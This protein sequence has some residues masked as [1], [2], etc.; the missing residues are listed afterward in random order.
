MGR[1]EEFKMK[2]TKIV[3]EYV[4]EEVKKIFNNKT[5]IERQWDKQ[6]EEMNED[7]KIMEMRIKTL[8]EDMKTNFAK[9]YNVDETV[10]SYY[11]PSI[12]IN[13]WRGIIYL[14][15]KAKEEEQKRT[16][17]AEKAI[18][19]IL[20]SLELGGNKKVLEEMLLKLKSEV[21]K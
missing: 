18:K 15:Q 2:V 11:S 13:H 20:I 6:K 16:E 5:E 17:R 3:R 19:D 7:C 4:E 1:N 8:V 9:K 12:S 14:E 21:Q 10:L